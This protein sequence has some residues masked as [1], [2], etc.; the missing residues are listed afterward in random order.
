MQGSNYILTSSLIAK[1][2]NAEDQIESS[3]WNCKNGVVLGGDCSL[4]FFPCSG[5]AIKRRDVSPLNGTPHAI[6][7]G[8]Y[9]ADRSPSPIKTRVNATSRRGGVERQRSKSRGQRETKQSTKQSKEKTP[10]EEK[11]QGE[12]QRGVL[13][14]AIVFVPAENPESTTNSQQAGHSIIFLVSKVAEK[15]EEETQTK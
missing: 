15:N 5:S 12:T 7:A 6:T 1:L 3:L 14:F 9:S 4:V 2:Q 11:N 10:K 8:C 13:V